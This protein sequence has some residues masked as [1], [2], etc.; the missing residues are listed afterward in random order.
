MTDCFEVTIE[1]DLCNVCKIFYGTLE[2]NNKCYQRYQLQKNLTNRQFSPYTFDEIIAMF[3]DFQKKF[4]TKYT[5]HNDK[6][7]DFLMK[8]L[9]GKT[10]GDVY[11][12]LKGFIDDFPQTAMSASQA[13][14]IFDM[15]IETYQKKEDTWRFV[16]AI[17]PLVIDVWNFKS[18]NHTNIIQCYYQ[19]FGD[20]K[21]PKSKKEFFL[22][23]KNFLI[24]GFESNF[25]FKV[26]CIMCLQN[27]TCVEKLIECGY[28]HNFYH[29]DCADKCYSHEDSYHK[30]INCKQSWIYQMHS[31]NINNYINNDKINTKNIFITRNL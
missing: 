9:V 29:N 5:I 11:A 24:S 3:N 25:D 12:H 14:K 4:N 22:L 31:F 19:D 13:S 23:C 21:C 2:Q 17:L 6:Q 1:N 27:I 15:C 18:K 8:I 10:P 28:C 20:L 26:N 16:H 7:F 30:C